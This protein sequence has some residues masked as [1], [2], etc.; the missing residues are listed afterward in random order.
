MADEIAYVLIQVAQG[1]SVS[2]VLTARLI[3]EAGEPFALLLPGTAL[4]HLGKLRLYPQ[5]LKQER[6]PSPGRPALYRHETIL[7]AP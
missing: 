3:Y 7:V 1:S 2:P 6:A 5:H 4:S